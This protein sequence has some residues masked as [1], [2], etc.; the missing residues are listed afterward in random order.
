MA[1]A[2]LAGAAAAAAV[3]HRAAGARRGPRA[4]RGSAPGRPLAPAFT[5]DGAVLDFLARGDSLYLARYAEP[6]GTLVEAYRFPGGQ[7]R[8]SWVLEPGVRLVHASESRLTVADDDAAGS[9]PVLAG[10][11][12]ENGLA[13]WSRPG[14]ERVAVTDAVVLAAPPHAGS[15]AVPELVAFASDDGV[16]R[17]SAQVPP[18]TRAGGPPDIGF[19]PVVGSGVAVV[20]ADGTVQV[21]DVDSGDLRWNV[22]VDV[23]WPVR[24][25]LVVG[26][27][28]ILYPVPQPEPAAPVA[29]DLGS[30][31]VL[32]RAEPTA[33]L[34]PCADAL[35][36]L[37][38]SGTRAVDPRTGLHLW[39][40]TDWHLAG[41]LDERHIVVTAG[42]PVD[43]ST[44][45][46]AG[47]LDARTGRR[48]REFGSWRVLGS[49]PGLA[50]VQ[51]LHSDGTS[52]IAK[53]DVETGSRT[54]VGVWESWLPAPRC[55][56]TAVFVAC[57]GTARV[58]VWAR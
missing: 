10:L 57:A 18:G 39:R 41:T 8:W 21:R 32:W 52:L 20:L 24:G 29:V 46:P 11:D 6:R 38:G 31:R 58:A 25:L 42:D 53:V 50:I 12:T 48:V 16:V 51:H 23:T 17:W 5:L 14:Y 47:V 33:R 15:G 54:V 3:A 4:R 44:A 13:V 45:A 43:A 36:D 49:A 34:G 19:A 1:A 7:L 9:G 37:A 26:D 35:C 56:S 55:R 40:Q 2:G 28:A 30:G 27:V 22:K